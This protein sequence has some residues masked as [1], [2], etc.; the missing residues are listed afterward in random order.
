MKVV[1]RGSAQRSAG[2][3]V[4][5]RF[6]MLTARLPS[7]MDGQQGVMERLATLSGRDLERIQVL[8][9]V[10]K[11][12]RLARC[13]DDA[14]VSRELAR[15]LPLEEKLE[16]IAFAAHFQLNARAVIV[17]DG[18]RVHAPRKLSEGKSLYLFEVEQGAWRGIFQVWSDEW[19]SIDK[20]EEKVGALLNQAGISWKIIYAR[21]ENTVMTRKAFEEM[22]AAFIQKRHGEDRQHHYC[23]VVSVKLADRLG[24]SEKAMRA[25][26]KIMDRV[27]LPGEL[28]CRHSENEWMVTVFEDKE[29]LREFM[30]AM[31]RVAGNARKLKSEEARKIVESLQVTA[32]STVSFSDGSVELHEHRV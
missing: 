14:W 2:V 4:F 20:V 16:L 13:R 5:G 9:D 32:K 29:R 8:S 3:R 7:G 1:E 10:L 28:A 12:V 27:K 23:Y 24:D 30:Q 25:V 18:V 11:S 31:K 17:L 6:G 19:V 26:K 15:R 21:E 22:L